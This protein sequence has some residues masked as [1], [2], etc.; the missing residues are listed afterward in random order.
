MMRPTAIA[1]AILLVNFMLFGL[2]EKYYAIGNR[3]DVIKVF[4]LLVIFV[5]TNN[6]D[7]VTFSERQSFCYFLADSFS[8]GC[9]NFLLLFWKVL[10]E[11]WSA[12]E[13]C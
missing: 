6:H 9:C 5:L 11:G 7:V 2:I 3:V 12:E 13:D 1:R 8:S 4:C 10:M